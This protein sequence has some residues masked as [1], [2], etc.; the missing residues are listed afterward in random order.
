[1]CRGVV[2]QEAQAVDG[3]RHAPHA[4]PRRV[5]PQFRPVKVPPPGS[6][7]VGGQGDLCVGGEGGWGHVQAAAARGLRTERL[8]M[9]ATVVERGECTSARQYRSNPAA[10][11]APLRDSSNLSVGSVGA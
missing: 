5:P 6:L 4:E 9:W 3:Q 7:G 8:W 1:M 10:Q 11:C 2:V